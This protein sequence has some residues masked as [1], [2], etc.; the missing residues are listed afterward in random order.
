MDSR[1]FGAAYRSREYTVARTKEIYE[2]YYDVKYP[3]HERQAGRPLRVSPAY[4]RL[5]ELGAAFGE[6]SG[7]ERANWFE[8]NARARRRVASAA[9]LGREALVAGDR[10]RALAPA[11]R[12]RRSSTSRR[13]RRSR[14][15]AP[16]AAAFLEWLCANRVARDV[17]AITYTQMLNP[18]GGIECDFTVTRLAEE[19]FRIVTGTAFGQHDLAWIR[20]HAPDGRLGAGR[21]RHVRATPAS[22][23][24]G[25]RAGRSCSR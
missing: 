14:C 19:R 15:A 18:R 25:P 16:G 17:G 8:P 2:T 11:A 12:R 22:G 23:S 5:G 13:S 6:K 3:G 4:A 20:Q 21:G 10:R 1:R 24:G 9:R 7:W